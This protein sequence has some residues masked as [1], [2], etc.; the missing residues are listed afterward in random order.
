MFI[1]FQIF[2]MFIITTFVFLVWGDV[3]TKNTI[4]YSAL[5]VFFT[6]VLFSTFILKFNQ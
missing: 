5:A 6:A 3:R 2:L 4:I 1:T